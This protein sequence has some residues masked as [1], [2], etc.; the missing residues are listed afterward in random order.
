MKRLRISVVAVGAAL[1]GQHGAAMDKEHRHEQHHRATKTPIEH[2]IVII[3]ENHSFDN[4]YATLEASKGQRVTNLLSKGIVDKFGSPGKNFF[5]AA[6]HE[7]EDHGD[8]SISPIVTGLYSVLPQPQTTYATGLPQGVADDRYPD[9][10]PNGPFQLTNERASYDSHFGDP[11]HRFFQMWQMTDKGKHNLFTWVA[12]TTGIGSQNY[13]PGGPVPGH[14]FQGGEAMGFFNVQTGDAPYFKSLA[15]DFAISDNYHQFI[16][17]G[18]GANFIALVSADVAFF[19]HMQNGIA[20]IAP[21]PATQIENPNALFPYNNFYTQDGYSG[22]SYVNCSDRAQPGVA[23]IRDYLDTRRVFRDGNCAKDTYYLVNNY[24]L[25][26]DQT[27]KL[28]TEQLDPTT[29]EP[30]L[31]DFG[32]SYGIHPATVLP[33]QSNPTIADALS[34]KGISWKYYSGGR[35]KVNADGSTTPDQPGEYCG[36]CDPLTGFASI[37]ETQLK[38]N[39]QGVPNFFEDVKT[40]TLPAVSYIRP[41][42]KNAGHPANATMPAFESFVRDVVEQ[43][44]AKPELWNKTAILVTVDEGGGYYDSGYIQPIDFFGDG[45]RIPLIAV[46]PW[47][48][49]G[50]IDHGYGDHASII[51]FIEKNWHLKPLSKRSRDNLPNPLASPHNPYVP[52]NR[53]AI[54]DLM[55]LFDFDRDDDHGRDPL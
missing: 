24:A 33:P 16:M 51:K 10:L 1:F 5:L 4:V 35:D 52:V 50:H 49:K 46:S 36:I 6:Q 20:E 53:P 43:I 39:L 7:A 44:K 12:V 3:G 2:V 32:G 23:S 47:A 30:K 11:V 17:G 28:K 29:W 38:H 25:A 21:P 37:M 14:T 13:S 22:G 54:S 26:Y 48:K 19:R 41:Y 31:V 15:R 45:T 9:N 27:G 55:G 18:T 34:A 42:E 40:G 8:Y